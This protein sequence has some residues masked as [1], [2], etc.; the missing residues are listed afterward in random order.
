[1]S[2]R[3]RNP[4]R[5]PVNALNMESHSH[6]IC[7]PAPKPTDFQ[8]RLKE[9]QILEVDEVEFSGSRKISNLAVLG[10]GS[11]GI[12]VVAYRMSQKVALKIRRVDAG[13]GTMQHEAEMLRRANEIG[14]GPRLLGVTA[15]FLAMEYIEGTLLPEWIE[16]L[17]GKD[18]KSRLR[19]VLRSVL[20]QTWKLDQGGLDHGELSH[21]PKH[22]IVSRA[23]APCLVDFET[24]SLSRRVSNVTSLVQY[25]FI[26]SPVSAAIKKRLPSINQ[27]NLMRALLTYKKAKTRENYGQLLRILS[28]PREG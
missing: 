23:N 10:K 4:V 12:V 15:N 8:H 17:E 18:V 13:R 20:E 14:V 26:G 19:R 1:M 27:D 22:I 9:L 21:A 6:V 11:I 28:L 7:Y 16:A 5:I 24:A 25:L 2:M 3:P